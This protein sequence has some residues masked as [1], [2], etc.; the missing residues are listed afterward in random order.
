MAR[1]DKAAAPSIP[2]WFWESVESEA[3]TGSVEVQE[4]DVCYRSW[5]NPQNPGV[6]LIHGMYAHSRWWDF[7]APQLMQDYYLVA[8]DLTGMGDSDYRYKYSGATF[9]QE[10][11]AVAD[12]SG[13]SNDAILVAHSFGGLIAVKTINTAA[14]RFAGLVLVDS[15]IRHPDEPPLEYPLLNAAASIYPDKD[16]AIARFRLQPPQDCKNDYLLKYI[17]RQSLRPEDGGWTWKFDEDLPDSLSGVERLADEY[18]F[19][20]QIDGFKLSVIY[21]QQSKLFSPRSLEYMRELIAFDF[22]SLAIA[23]A[24]HHVFLDQPLDFVAALRKMLLN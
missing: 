2:G 11:L 9:V 12:A 20:G 7:I 3:N 23:E 14:Q 21:G 16:A 24:Q 22:P 13:L 5:G 8:M 17:A 18:V 4:C 6:L 15:G 19:L 10:V 1:W